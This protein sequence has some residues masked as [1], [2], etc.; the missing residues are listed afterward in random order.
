MQVTKTLQKSGCFLLNPDTFDML[1][2]NVG[3]KI[4]DRSMSLPVRNEE[5]ARELQKTPRRF[6]TAL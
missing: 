6:T 1:L 3:H 4:L 5:L 2:D